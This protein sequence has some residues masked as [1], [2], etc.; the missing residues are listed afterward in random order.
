ML[1]L[2]QIYVHC[3]VLWLS[4]ICP[5][6]RLKKGLRGAVFVAT[7]KSRKSKIHVLIGS[8]AASN[9]KPLKGKKESR[10]KARTLFSLYQGFFLT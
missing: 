3:F 9:K 8:S 7:L 4:H 10:H 1:F 2:Y 5:L 6:L